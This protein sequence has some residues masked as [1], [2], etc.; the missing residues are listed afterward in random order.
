[1]TINFVKYRNG[2]A[3]LKATITETNIGYDLR[4]GFANGQISYCG[5]YDNVHAPMCE[6]EHA[7]FERID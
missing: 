3:V 6:L 7:G 2:I 5:T 1:M 4:K